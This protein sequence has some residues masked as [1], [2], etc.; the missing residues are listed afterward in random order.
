MQL[1]LLWQI[2]ETCLVW[3]DV[4]IFLHVSAGGDP[5]EMDPEK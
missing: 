2:A 4:R 5:A 3:L 1:L